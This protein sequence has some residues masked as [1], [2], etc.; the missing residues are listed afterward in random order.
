M[1]KKSRLIFILPVF[2]MFFLS[3]ISCT[4]E[5]SKQS[6]FTPEPPTS[7]QHPIVTD[8]V[9]HPSRTSTS[10]PTPTTTASSTDTPTHTLPTTNT[11]SLTPTDTQTLTPTTPFGF[12]PDDAIIIYLTHVGTGGPVACGDSLVAIRT[13]NI[14]TKDIEKDIQLAIDTLFSIGQYSGGLYNAT[15][16]SSLRFGGVT[17][18]K[19]EA[20][21]ELGGSYVKPKDACDASRYR[22]QVWSTIQQFPEVNRAIPR[23]R[24]AL[25]GDLLAVY[26]DSGK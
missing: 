15:Y 14:R 18:T 16:P 5:L 22:A 24:N 20:V 25:L 10:E 26:S 6:T 2:V 11:P 7:T 8:T 1:N 13:G 9:I 4:N 19:G 17:I 23:Y 3:S 21:V 12:I